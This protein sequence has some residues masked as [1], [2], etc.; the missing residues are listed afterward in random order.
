MS[1]TQRMWT[2]IVLSILLSFNFIAL[3]GIAFS[4]LKAICLMFV[5]DIIGIGFLFFVVDAFDE[6]VHRYANHLVNSQMWMPDLAN[7]NR[8]LRNL[9][10]GKAV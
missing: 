10:K 8:R 5:L 9:L 4:G 1:H 2:Y 3:L 7:E 6:L